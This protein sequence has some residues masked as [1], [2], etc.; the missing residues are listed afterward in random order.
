MS[1]TVEIALAADEG[2]TQSNSILAL[3]DIWDWE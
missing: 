1:D 3:R 2:I